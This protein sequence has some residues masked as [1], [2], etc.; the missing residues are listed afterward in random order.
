M[1]QAMGTRSVCA[2]IGILLLACVNLACQST[3]GSP[4]L[5]NAFVLS[6]PAA[7]EPAWAH[8][9]GRVDYD[10]GNPGAVVIEIQFHDKDRVSSLYNV[11]YGIARRPGILTVDGRVHLNLPENEGFKGY[12]RRGDIVIS[13]QGHDPAMTRLDADR[14]EIR[15]PVRS[16]EAREAIRAGGTIVI[17]TDTV[18][19]EQAFNGF[20]LQD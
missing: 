13:R 12:E 6:P 8:A 17:S 3:P 5:A 20:V 15:I 16:S 18:Y 1:K 7:S 14:W 11:A 9:R 4:P 19:F 10:G 2:V